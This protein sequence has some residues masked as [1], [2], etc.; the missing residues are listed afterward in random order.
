MDAA[1]KAKRNRT[2]EGEPFAPD[3]RHPGIPWCAPD[4]LIHALSGYMTEKLFEYSNIPDH[5]IAAGFTDADLVLGGQVMGGN[6]GWMTKVL[7]WNP[8]AELGEP[9]YWDWA[10]PQPTI[11]DR[12]RVSLYA[13]GVE[14]ERVDAIFCDDAHALA[15]R[16]LSEVLLENPVLMHPRVRVEICMALNLRS[17]TCSV[18]HAIALTPNARFPSPLDWPVGKAPMNALREFANSTVVTRVLGTALRSPRHKDEL[19]AAKGRSYFAAAMGLNLARPGLL[20]SL[21][22]LGRLMPSRDVENQAVGRILED[23]KAIHR[24]EDSIHKAGALAKS[25]IN[26]CGVME[27]KRTRNQAA[28]Y[29]DEGYFEYVS[30]LLEDEREKLPFELRGQVFEAIFGTGRADYSCD[31]VAYNLHAVLSGCAKSG[32]FDGTEATAAR[33]IHQQLYEVGW[34]MP[35][36]T[37]EAAAA[38]GYIR[39]MREFGIELQ[40]SDFRLVKRDGAVVPFEESAPGWAAAMRVDVAERTMREVFER[41]PAAPAPADSVTTSRRR[42]ASV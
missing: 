39:T 35:A 41:T 26:A 25:L 18:A 19:D 11:A 42:R 16:G 32:L 38:L 7:Q 21:Y 12:L 20:R 9:G 34:K 24:P 22:D 14:R 23:W 4:A 2:A 10:P 13:L 28:L 5:F 29:R 15:Q 30:K 33:W 36:S 6:Y 37:V 1:L 31:D 40:Q 17:G 8:K 27:G 3:V